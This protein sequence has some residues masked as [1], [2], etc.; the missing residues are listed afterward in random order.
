[1]NS[2]TIKLLHSRKAPRG[3]ARL[4]LLQYCNIAIL[5]Y[6]NSIGHSVVVVDVSRKSLKV[7]AMH[8]TTNGTPCE[9]PAFQCTT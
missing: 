4:L 6:C 2:S 8:C 1:V 3:H 7:Q 9:N 5:Q